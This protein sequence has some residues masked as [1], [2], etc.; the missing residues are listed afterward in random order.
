MRKYN[1]QQFKQSFKG[2]IYDLVIALVVVFALNALIVQNQRV[3]GNSMAPTMHEG[4]MVIMNKLIYH[5][6]EP[7][8]G[9]IIG[10][11]VEA[12][13]KQV[14]KRIIGMPGDIIDY[15]EHM[16]YL[17]DQVILTKEPNTT[18][19]KG[20]ITYPYEVPEAHYFVIGDNYQQSI[21]SRYRY[22]GAIS[23]EVIKGRID[24]RIWPLTQL[25][26]IK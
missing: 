4:D 23:R 18:L 24:L 14:V 13:D 8:R 9:D 21:D 22:I 6:T 15:R 7:K 12:L 5:F 1:V 25:A 11:Y 20:D 3:A 10:F 17:N 19:I 2:L 16:L 26:F